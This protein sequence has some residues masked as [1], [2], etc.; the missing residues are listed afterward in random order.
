LNVFFKEYDMNTMEEPT[1]LKLKLARGSALERGIEAAQNCGPTEEQLE[2]LERKVLAGLGATA[3]VAT[4]VAVAQATHPPIVGATAAW[5]SAGSVKLITVLVAGVALSGGAVV[6]WRVTK[7]DAKESSATT[8]ARTTASGISHKLPKPL[9]VEKPAEAPAVLPPKP[10]LEPAPGLAPA[11]PAPLPVSRIKLRDTKTENHLPSSER[12]ASEA[13]SLALPS[14]RF[15]P[16]VPERKGSQVDEEVALLERA[17]RAL[18]RSPSHALSLAN[19]H[20]T[21]FP[22]SAMDQERE[23]IAIS[24]LVALGRTS[25]ARERVDRF[26]RENPGSVYQRQ[27]Q[28]AI[29]SPPPRM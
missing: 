6:A 2:A 27:M 14:V 16:P 9:P 24:A 15:V 4:V 22:G 21:R 3:A 29:E 20:A 17:N 1:R 13:P 8:T 23:L 5:L 11:T 28:K 26:V 19:E 7:P 12:P 18:A 10:A 25:E